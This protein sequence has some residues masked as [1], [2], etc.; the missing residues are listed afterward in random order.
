MVLHAAQDRLT[1][2]Q[3]LYVCCD[4]ATVPSRGP[5]RV[6]GILKTGDKNLFIARSRNVSNTSSNTSP[7]EMEPRCVLD[8][9]VH[10]SAQRRGIGGALF[11]HFLRRENKNPAR[12]AYD[13][14][15]EKLFA[16]LAKNFSLTKYQPQTNNFVV[17]DAYFAVKP[18]PASA[19]KELRK[20]T[21]GRGVGLAAAARAKAAAA[22]AARQE[23]EKE[24][25]QTSFVRDAVATTTHGTARMYYGRPPSHTS[26]ARRGVRSVATS[27]IPI[28]PDQS[29]SVEL[30]GRAETF[31]ASSET[32]NREIAPRDSNRRFAERRDSE[33]ETRRRARDAESAGAET[34]SRGSSPSLYSSGDRGIIGD[35]AYGATLSPPAPR[36]VPRPPRR[37]TPPGRIERLLETNGDSSSNDASDDFSRNSRG[38]ASLDSGVGGESKRSFSSRG[39]VSVASSSRGS[40]RDLIKTRSETLKQGET[41]RRDQ[42]NP[43]PPSLRGNSYASFVRG[44]REMGREGARGPRVANPPASSRAMANFGDA[45]SDGGGVVPL[46]DTSPIRRGEYGQWRA[47]KEG[48]YRARAFVKTRRAPTYH[49]ASTQAPFLS[50]VGGGVARRPDQT[51]RFADAPNEPPSFALRRLSVRAQGPSDEDHRY[52]AS[53]NDARSRS[54]VHDKHSYGAQQNVFLARRAA[55][56]RAEA[57]ARG[58]VRFGDFRIPENDDDARSAR[59]R[60]DSARAHMRAGYRLGPLY[61][62]RRDYGADALTRRAR[63]SDAPRA[64]P[65][66]VRVGRRAMGETL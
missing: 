18:R 15:S 32:P 40:S 1:R 34:T 62:E 57:Q 43:N 55:F 30:G 49:Y 37:A 53:L 13:R 51:G 10:E 12:L 16:F 66:L 54:V 26:A 39:E 48:Y 44:V 35:R 29:H 64:E 9:Y 33:R 25:T 22:R 17:F 27:S 60:R 2:D 36:H 31:R 7:I 38:G 4:G 58:D 56:E 59:F 5:S 42:P 11:D 3:I 28:V 20:L 41:F 23:A 61:G 46:E 50:S 47:P 63:Q 45:A 65:E 6:V 24:K 8:F 52:P 14:P 19:A 21:Q